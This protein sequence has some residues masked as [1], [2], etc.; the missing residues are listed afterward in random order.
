VSVAHGY[1][2]L[3]A[4]PT[5]MIIGDASTNAWFVRLD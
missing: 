1:A 2:D 4:M 3:E 5:D